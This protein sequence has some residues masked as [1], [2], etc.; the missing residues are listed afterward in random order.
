[1]GH[2]GRDLHFWVAL[3]GNEYE[4]VFYKAK[5][6][7][8]MKNKTE[9]TIIDSVYSV[10]KDKKKFKAGD[11]GN[12]LSLKKLTE[13]FDLEDNKYKHHDILDFELKIICEGLETDINE[14]GNNMGQDDSTDLVDTLTNLN[15]SANSGTLMDNNQNVY[16][17]PEINI[18]GKHSINFNQKY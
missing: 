7:F 11:L 3:H 18:P 2:I 16:E 12:V 10:D 5:L 4:E 9:N 15:L 8:H 6:T 17:A 14:S 13:Y 1:M